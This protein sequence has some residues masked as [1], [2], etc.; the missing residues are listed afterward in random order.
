MFWIFSEIYTST[1]PDHLNNSAPFEITF[2]K[3]KQYYSGY[4]PHRVASTLF[5]SLLEWMSFL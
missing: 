4:L 2:I 3:S 5:P 1:K